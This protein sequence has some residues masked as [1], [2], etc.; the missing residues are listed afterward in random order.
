MFV[1]GFIGS[2]AMNLVPR[3]L[4]GRR[5]PAGSPASGR[6]TCA[7]A[8]AATDGLRFDA[9]V[10]VSST[11]ATSSSCTSRATGRSLLAKLPVEERST[12]ASVESAVPEQPCTASTPRRASAA[13]GRHVY[14]ARRA[15]RAQRPPDPD[16]ARQAARRAGRARGA[17][18][19]RGRR[20][21]RT[22]AGVRRPV[23]ELRVPRGQERAGPAREPDPPPAPPHRRAVVIDEEAAAASDKVT[24]GSKVVVEDE[25]GERME[26]EISSAGGVSPESPLGRALLG[27][28]VGDERKVEAPRGSW[29][30]R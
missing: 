12:G 14:A 27:A 23:R 1:A 15:R 7:S 18:A 20:R 16:A 10:E 4:A 28:R 21:H 30:A 24:I 9:R 6:S 5:R 13:E 22:G 17:A 11:S 29:R 25:A 8:R 2:P 3:R 26:V 19:C